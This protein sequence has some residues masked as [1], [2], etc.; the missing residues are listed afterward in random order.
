MKLKNTRAA[1]LNTPRTY[2]GTTTHRHKPSRSHTSSDRAAVSANVVMKECPG[3]NGAQSPQIHNQAA[4]GAANPACPYEVS[5]AWWRLLLLLSAGSLCFIGTRLPLRGIP[6]MQQCKYFVQ[7]LC[8]KGLCK[9][10]VQRLCAKG[11]CKGW[12]LTAGSHVSCAPSSQMIPKTRRDG[13]PQRAG[14]AV[15]CWAWP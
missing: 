5:H 8:A 9:G 13:S 12:N 1:P 14:M 4:T 6:C 10:F 3:C 15:H 11:L 2:T 7:R